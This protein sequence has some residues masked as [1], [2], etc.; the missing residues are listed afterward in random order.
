MQITLKCKKLKI[1]TLCSTISL[2]NDRMTNE[3]A[4][5]VPS[6]PHRPTRIEIYE[7]CVTQPPKT[8]V[9]KGV[10]RHEDLQN[11]EPNSRDSKKTEARHC[12]ETVFSRGMIRGIHAEKF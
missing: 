12:W 1:E 11:Q 4:L 7:R 8:T 6:I 2:Q 10:L 9:P 3:L 5:N